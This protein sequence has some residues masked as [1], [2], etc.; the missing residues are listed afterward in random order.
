MF[1]DKVV[2]LIDK[3]KD[4]NDVLDSTDLLDWPTSFF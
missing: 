2:S 1:M 3:I 4:A